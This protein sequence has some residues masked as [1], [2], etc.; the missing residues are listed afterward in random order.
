MD[1]WLYFAVAGIVVAI[2]VTI[3]IKNRSLVESYKNLTQQNGKLVWFDPRGKQ[4][5]LIEHFEHFLIMM[6]S[7]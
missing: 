4:K 1:Y 6:F 7:L 5:L 3:V 2:V